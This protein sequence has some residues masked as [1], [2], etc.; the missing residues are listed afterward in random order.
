MFSR[1]TEVSAALANAEKLRQRRSVDRVHAAMHG[2]LQ[3]ICAD[4][5]IVVAQ[6]QPT[7]NRLLKAIKRDQGIS[8]TCP[9]LSK[10]GRLNRGCR[11]RGCRSDCRWNS[12]RPGP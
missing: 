10:R 4:E 7:M 11:A 12:A 6:E 5:N 9:V 2:Y 3:Q 8:E 1:S